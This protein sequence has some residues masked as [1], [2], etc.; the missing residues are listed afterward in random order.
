MKVNIKTTLTSLVLCLGLISQTTFASSTCPMTSAAVVSTA[1]EDSDLGALSQS[2]VIP[3]GYE[4]ITGMVKFLSNEWPEYY[5]SKYNDTYLARFSAPGLVSILARG[6]LNSSPW[7]SGILGYNG[8][9]KEESYTIDASGLAGNTA[10]LHYEV[11]D[12]GDKIV[13]SALA[14]DAVNVIRTEQYLH[15][16]S[17][18]FTSPGVIQ[19]SFGQAVRITFTNNN[20][21][22]ASITVKSNGFGG[23]T[24]GSLV[25]PMQ[26]VTFTFI[27]GGVEPTYWSFDVGTSSDALNVEYSIEST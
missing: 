17:G 21:I 9:S 3:P 15:A 11:R 12:V 19:G 16:G 2:F 23:T 4:S 10:T 22:G 24:K 14:V 5:G 13:D 27:N 6:N 8:Q 20:V 25:L 18:Y 26:S 7:K 1:G